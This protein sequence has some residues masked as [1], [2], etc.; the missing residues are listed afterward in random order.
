MGFQNYN[1]QAYP[2]VY[3]EQSPDIAAAESKS[4]A[5]LV[6]GIISIVTSCVCIGLILGPLAIVKG[7]QAR[8]VLNDQHTNFYIA[9]A[10]LITGI[11]GLA[12]SVIYLIT[13]VFMF[14]MT[15]LGLMMY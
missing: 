6:M 13:W 10:G 4:V 1:N 7:K 12:I 5:S 14:A 9:L 2:P 11:I 3:V 8:Q 15:G